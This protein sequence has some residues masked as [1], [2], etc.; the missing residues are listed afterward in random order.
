M[1]EM[2]KLLENVGNHLSTHYLSYI[3]CAI[4]LWMGIPGLTEKEVNF[5]EPEKTITGGWAFIFSILCVLT[6]LTAIFNIKL[7]IPL[8]LLIIIVSITAP[9]TKMH[10]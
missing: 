4:F 6:G 3:F 7:I 9:K 2:T 5:I 1:I 10:S 8:V